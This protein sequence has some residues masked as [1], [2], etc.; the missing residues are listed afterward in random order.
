MRILIISTTKP[1]KGSG[2]GLTEYAYQLVTHMKPLLGKYTIIDEL[3]AIKKSKKNNIRGLIKANTEFKIRLR[4]IAHRKYDIIHITDQEVGFAAKILKKAKVKAKI[5]TTVHDL[6][7]FEAGLHRGMAQRAYN[8]MVKGSTANAIE[9]SDFI[10]CNSSQTYK[11]LIRRFGKR[12]NIAVVSHGID[13]KIISARLHKKMYKKGKFIVGYIGALA[14][15]KNVILILRTA[16]ILKG[17]DTYRFVINGTGAELQNLVNFKKKNGLDNVEFCGYVPEKDKVRAYDSF[18]AFAFPSRYEGFG[19]PI[20]EAQARGLP[21]MIYKDG[22]IPNEVKKFCIET[23]CPEQM[24]EVI[25][26]LEKNGYRQE[27]RKLGIKHAGGFTWNKTANGTIDV[28]KTLLK[29]ETIN[30]N[31]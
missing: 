10:L 7:R 20:L 2:S 3:F 9:H 11:T 30:V 26:S 25:R 12:K 4:R 17:D 18:D 29:R 8:W 19:N 21:V 16:K 15:H 13:D 28:Y 31:L 27:P 6:S 1:Y 22:R 24:A 14:L 23:G 5:V